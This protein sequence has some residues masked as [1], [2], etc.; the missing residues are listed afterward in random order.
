MSATTLLSV[1]SSV[2]VGSVLILAPWTRLWEANYLLQA[3]PWLRDVLLHHATRGAITGLGF[4]N[5]LVAWHDL[6]GLW[7]QRHGSH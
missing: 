5:V 6:V 3:S 7:R 4:V 2:L 1:V